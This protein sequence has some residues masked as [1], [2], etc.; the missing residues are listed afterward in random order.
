MSPNPPGP[1]A[2]SRRRLLAGGGALFLTTTTGSLLVARSGGSGRADDDR[3]RDGRAATPEASPTASAASGWMPGASRIPLERNFVLGDRDAQRGL[4]LHVQEGEGSLY[5]RFN[6]P[7]GKTSSHFW[8]SRDGE[9]EQY[10]SV[11]DRAWAQVEGNGSWASV[12]TSGF[13]TRPLTE[14]QV[15]AVARIYAWGAGAHGWPAAVSEHPDQ[16]GLGI[17]AM[18]GAAWGGHACPGTLRSGQRAE[19]MRRVRER[20]PGGE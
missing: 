17:H 15:D 19:I 11:L 13:A 16:P 7:G 5:E 18:G 20:L 3:G 14:A 8:V 2:P 6:T 10:V 4:V 9:T 1:P 12:E